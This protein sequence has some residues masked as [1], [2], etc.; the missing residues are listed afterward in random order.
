MRK[1]FI[2][3][4]LSLPILSSAKTCLQEEAG[5]REIYRQGFSAE[6]E[7][8]LEV[9]ELQSSEGILYKIHSPDSCGTRGC[10]FVLAHSDV[11]GCLV[12]SFVGNGFMKPHKGNDYTTFNQTVKNL[13]VDKAITHKKTYQ[14][15]LKSR[16]FEEK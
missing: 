3:L 5:A 14:L 15:N 11:D 6:T 1:L 2:L 8:E 4:T 16:I 12:L 10:E 13:P 7:S 9:T